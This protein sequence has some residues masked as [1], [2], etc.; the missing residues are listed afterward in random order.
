MF[1]RRRF[2]ASLL[3]GPAAAT[4]SEGP[5]PVPAD[6]QRIWIIVGVNWEH[7]DELNYS[8]GDYLTEYVF[9]DKS[10]ADKICSDLIRQFRDSDDPDDYT[11]SS[12]SEP[13]G[14]RD[15]SKDRKWDW[16]FG[17][18]ANPRRLETDFEDAFGWVSLPFDVREM[19]LPASAIA[20]QALAT[21]RLNE[22]L[23]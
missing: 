8:V 20:Q 15:W 14:W 10:L 4:L 5:P 11:G 12:V 23:V 19:R 9:T 17:L 13:D 22:D 7:N 6:E 21:K 3:A 18:T 2:L 1:N 16:L